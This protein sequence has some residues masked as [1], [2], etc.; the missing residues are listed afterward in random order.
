MTHTV[1]HRPGGV[2]SDTLPYHDM[3]EISVMPIA[4]G[5]IVD[6]EAIDL[7]SHDRKSLKVVSA[8]IIFKGGVSGWRIVNGLVQSKGAHDDGRE[9]AV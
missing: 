9:H 8:A 4:S 6:T 1:V 7:Y 3:T 5:H 2:A